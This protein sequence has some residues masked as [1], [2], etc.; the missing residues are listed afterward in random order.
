IIDFGGGFSAKSSGTFGDYQNIGVGLLVLLVVIGFNCCKSPL[1]RMGGIA[2]GLI[3]GYICALFLGMVDFSQMSKAAFITIPVPFKYGFS[4]NFAHFL[5]VAIIYLLSV[6]EAV[7]DLTATALVSGQKI[8][9]QEFQSR[10]KGGVMADG[11]V[12][13]AASAMSSLPLT[14]FAQ[15][16]GVIQMTGVASRHVGKIIAVILV[17]LGLFPGIGW[18]FTTIPAPVLGGAMT[19]MFSMIA[20]AGIRIILSNG[21]R[22]RETLIVATSLGLGLGVSYDPA[23]FH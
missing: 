14:T 3:V 5:V 1:L 2:I 8:Q 18:F 10:L 7:G 19:L 9:G 20:I 11:L 4:F 21:L 13:V 16:N 6:L 22:R 23:V 12:S 17:I 15:N